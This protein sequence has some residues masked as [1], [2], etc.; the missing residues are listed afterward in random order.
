MMSGNVV[1]IQD[2]ATNPTCPVGNAAAGSAIFPCDSWQVGAPS[3]DYYQ[4]MAGCVGDAGGCAWVNAV[5]EGNASPSCTACSTPNEDILAFLQTKM[6]ST[7]TSM[8][9]NPLSYFIADLSM[10]ATCPVGDA[11]AGS[12]AFPCDSWQ[13]GAPCNY[14]QEKAGCVGGSSS[15]RWSEMA[16]N[17]VVGVSCGDCSLAESDFD[18]F[19]KT[20]IGWTCTSIAGNPISYFITD[21]ATSANCPA[22]NPAAG[23]FPCDSW[24]APPT[25]PPTTTKIYSPTPQPSVTD[26]SFSGCSPIGVF[27][28][29]TIMMML[30]L[31]A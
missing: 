12:T 10:S 11:V 22:G 13:V 23:A 9:G 15:C 29:A 30:V 1:F 4:E 2:V 6:G 24:S 8:A 5:L 7:C 20:K 19:L 18:A 14:Y 31:R 16:L 25:M 28:L 17:G 21:Y 3:C 26:S 27:H